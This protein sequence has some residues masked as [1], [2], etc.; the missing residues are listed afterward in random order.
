MRN[1]Q[2]CD[3]GSVM[4]AV[5]PSCEH[6]D[7]RAVFAPFLLTSQVLMMPQIS[8]GDDKTRFRRGN[9]N[10]SSYSSSIASRCACRASIRDALMA[11]AFASCNS[12]VAKLRRASLKRL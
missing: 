11:L 6:D 1:G 9:R 5:D 2:D 7:D 8:V 3:L 10:T 12:V 4:A